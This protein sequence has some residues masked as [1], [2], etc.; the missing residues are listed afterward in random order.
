MSAGRI[1]N[2]KKH[3]LWA[4]SAP[5]LTAR[6]NTTIATENADSKLIITH[7][8]AGL[9]MEQET[10]VVRKYSTYFKWAVIPKQSVF[11]VGT[12]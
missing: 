8:K 7:H 3:C 2:A 5:L 12:F 1:A 11:N 6:E 9:V 4:I 10:S